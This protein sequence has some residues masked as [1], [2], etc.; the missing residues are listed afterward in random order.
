MVLGKCLS[1]SAYERYEGYEARAYVVRINNLVSHW[2]SCKELGF[3]K[4]YIKS[5]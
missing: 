5:R 1:R 4:E 3:R 2:L